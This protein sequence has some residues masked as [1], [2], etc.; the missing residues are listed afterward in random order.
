MDIFVRNVP[1]QSTGK[2]LHK[3]LLPHMRALGTDVF[4]CNKFKNKKLAL[5][6]VLEP[7]LAHRFLAMYGDNAG[8]S[9]TQNPQKLTYLGQPLYFSAGNKQPDPVLLQSLRKEAK[10]KAKNTQK[11]LPTT[12]LEREYPYLSL[13]CGVW[14]Y[15][16]T[17]LSFI[18]HFHDARRGRV[19]FGKQ[20]LALVVEPDN[21][22]RS[23]YRVDFPYNSIQSITL[24]NFQ[25]SSLTFTLAEAPR[26]FEISEF[27]QMLQALL[28][29]LHIGSRTR[30]VPKR[31]RISSLGPTHDT[32]VS[33][34]FVYRILLAEPSSLRHIDNL[35]KQ[36]QKLPPSISCPTSI[37][38]AKMSFH[39]EMQAL[40]LALKNPS[41]PPSFGVKFQMQRLAQNGFLAPALVLK[42]LPEVTRICARSGGVICIE[43]VRKLFRQI[44]YAG[45][46]ADPNAFDLETLLQLL[47]G[48]EETATANGCP[49]FD[50][51][52]QHSHIALIHKATV[53]PT[54]VFLEGPEPET[55]NR[56][57]RKYA[58]HT[59]FFLRVSFLDEDGVPLRFDKHVL[60]DEIYHQRFKG[61]LSAFIEVAGRKFEFLGFS[62]S[63]LREQTCWFMAPFVHN[64]APLNARE[65]IARLGDFTS[66]RSPAKCAARI[67]QA[68]SETN[69]TVKLNPGAVQVV[70]DIERN[71]RVFSDGVGTF[72]YDILKRVWRDYAFGRARPTLLQIRWAGT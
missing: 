12:R 3:F 2:Q 64:F 71:R 23:R 11:A 39:H 38:K 17:K 58:L 19:M 13:S 48:N 20:A 33:S 30:T 66:I 15:E 16:G 68:F 50:L 31:K 27:D 6:T 63:S 42:L 1:D 21:G 44:P 59:D 53:T 60:L 35:L 24:G 26:I 18:Y 41:E 70:P 5:V 28:N 56:V 54:G 29:N 10:D 8:R 67:G 7:V 37:M 25:D 22:L 69:G 65:V 9:P 72:S 57:L 4:N 52:Q 32:I 62:H 36:G 34:C 55:K 46:D 51:T 61:V 49:M 14:D 45:P 40:L 47:L 43:A